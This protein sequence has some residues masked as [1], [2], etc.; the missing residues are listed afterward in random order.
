MGQEREDPAPIQ[1]EED[2]EP[3]TPSPS[4]S[5]SSLSFAWNLKKQTLIEELARSLASDDG[6]SFESKIQATRDIR[7]LAKRSVTARS[8]LGQAGV[9]QPLISMLVSSDA[10]A[11]EAALLNLAVRNERLYQDADISKEAAEIQDYIE[12]LTHV[13]NASMQ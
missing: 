10:E 3:S 6:S 12:T 4:S 1:E 2:E 8:M 13:P 9:I 7:K 11:R 5:S